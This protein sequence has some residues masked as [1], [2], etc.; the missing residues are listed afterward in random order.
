MRWHSIP[1]FVLFAGCVTSTSIAPRD[2]AAVAGTPEGQVAQVS[3][4]DGW[5]SINGT[6]KLTRN[7]LDQVAVDMTAQA[8]P[9]RARAAKRR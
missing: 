7:S 9:P 6:E 3:T 5:H 4:S 8:P 2:L 1:L